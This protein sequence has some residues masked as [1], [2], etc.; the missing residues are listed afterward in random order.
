MLEDREMQIQRSSKMR[1]MHLIVCW[2]SYFAQMQ[3]DLVD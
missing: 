2:T 1:Q 3:L